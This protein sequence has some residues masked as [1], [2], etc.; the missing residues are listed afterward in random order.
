MKKGI[1]SSI[2]AVGIM[3]LGSAQALT[4]QAGTQTVGQINSLKG[5][6]K[7]TKNITIY[8]L[9]G[10]KFIQVRDRALLSN[11]DWF[12]NKTTSGTD[13]LTYYRVATSE[14]IPSSSVKLNA[15]SS[16][17]NNSNSPNSSNSNNSQA[18]RTMKTIY[19]RNW[20]AA[21]VNSN[22]TRTGNVL[23][24]HSAWR[25]FSDTVTI[26]GQK[27]YQISSNEFVSTFDTASSANVGQNTSTNTN[28]NT[29][30]NTNTNVNTNTTGTIVGNSATKV[31]HLPGQKYYK[32]SANHIVYFNTEQDAINAGY[33]K[34]RI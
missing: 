28:T 25:A 18:S 19:I 10:K 31:Y 14:W 30:N 33:H 11:T 2:I 1:L 9:K 32:I 5:T 3:L 15:P 13:G 29:N 27:Y 24:A 21:T 12:F 16:N 20:N 7:T 34:S 17:T 4:V 8:T 23:P 6:V 26:N 22:G